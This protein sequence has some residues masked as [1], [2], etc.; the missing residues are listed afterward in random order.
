MPS[1]RERNAKAS[2]R[3]NSAS[4]PVLAVRRGT[5]LRKYV[6]AFIESFAPTLTRAVVEGALGDQEKASHYEI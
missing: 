5:Y 4:R 1:L 6:Y 2:V 3:R